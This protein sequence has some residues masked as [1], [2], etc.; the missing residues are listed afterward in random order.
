MVQDTCGGL[1]TG[2]RSYLFGCGV[3]ALVQLRQE[4]LPE[5]RGQIWSV[6]G[7]TGQH[8]EPE[9][10]RM[11]NCSPDNAWHIITISLKLL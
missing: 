7:V 11:Y 3:V 2:R 10:I 5:V 9:G 8:S 1:N 4:H 6:S